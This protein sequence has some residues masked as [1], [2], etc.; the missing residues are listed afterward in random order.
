MKKQLKLTAAAL[1]LAV[2][3]STS[4]AADFVTGI[5]DIDS[6]HTLAEAAMLLSVGANAAEQN[7][8]LVSQVG[9]LNIAY[10]QQS[11]GTGS[12]F[13]AIIQDATSA[14]VSNVGYVFQAGTGNRAVI[15]QH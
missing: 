2:T 7:I 11:T 8:G 3:A 15:Y 12:N 13:A 1:L 6:V 4:F 9:D 5:N 14:T 10:I